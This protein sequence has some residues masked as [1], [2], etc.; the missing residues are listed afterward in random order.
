V[1]HLK[2]GQPPRSVRPTTSPASIMEAAG[3]LH[4]AMKVFLADGH[5]IP[6][7]GDNPSEESPPI[8]EI[9]CVNVTRIG[10]VSSLTTG[11]TEG[12]TFSTAGI[13]KAVIT[14]SRFRTEN[15]RCTVDGKK[16]KRRKNR[17]KVSDLTIC[18]SHGFIHSMK[19][20][21]LNPKNFAE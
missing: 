14:C 4:P 8:P 20:S 6:L 17:K 2:S 21:T 10:D 18:F 12:L 3:P 13:E 9:D 16:M 1:R 19:F 7:K 5:S 15:N 11:K